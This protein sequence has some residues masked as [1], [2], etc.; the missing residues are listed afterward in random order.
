MRVTQPVVCNV[1]DYEEY[2]GKIENDNARVI[3]PLPPGRFEKTYFESGATVREGDLLGEFVPFSDPK[4]QQAEEKVRAARH[5]RNEL[6]NS[7]DRAK[8]RAAD[9]QE[10]AAEDERERVISKA[11][12]MK[13]VAPFDG[14]LGGGPGGE[15]PFVISIAPQ[16]AMLV[17]FDV[18]ESAVLAHCRL[19]NRKPNWELSLPVVCAL[20]D[21]KSFPYRGK[22][23]SVGDGI[24]PTTNT[25]RR[26]ALVPNKDGIFLPGMS[27]RVR[28]ITGEPHKILA[29]PGNVDFEYLPDAGHENDPVPV[30]IVN[31]QNVIETRMVRFWLGFD[32][33]P[34]KNMVNFKGD[35]AGLLGV[36]EGLSV[37]DWVVL[38][39]KANG[40]APGLGAGSV[41]TPKKV[42]TPLP[43][44]ATPASGV[45]PPA[46]A[47]GE[48]ATGQI[49]IIHLKNANAPNAAQALERIFVT[50]GATTGPIRITVDKRLNA[51]LVQANHA[52]FEKIQQVTNQ[53][54]A[55]LVPLPE[56]RDQIA[57]KSTAPRKVAAFRPVVQSTP[58]YL[59]T[60]GKIVTL[61][62]PKDGP[63]K[64]LQFEIDQPTC[65]K[66]MQAAHKRNA[67]R[68]AG[69]DPFG[70][71]SA[72]PKPA[73]INLASIFHINYGY[74]T[75]DEK[76]FPHRAEF[77][78]WAEHI[79]TV[80]GA[81][82]TASIDKSDAIAAP[83]MSVLVRLDTGATH[84]NLAVSQQAI[85]AEGG[86]QFVYVVNDDNVV[87]RRAVEASRSQG[88]F[89][90]VTGVKR[91]EIV[92]ADPSAVEPGMSVRPDFIAGALLL[93]T[94]PLEFVETPLK[95]VVD[96][97]KD[98]LHIEMLLDT[99]G[100][101]AARVDPDALISINLRDM[102]FAS[103]FKLMLRQVGLTYVVED[104]DILIT[105]PGKQPGATVSE[106]TATIRLEHANLFDTAVTLDHRFSRDGATTGP[107]RI[108]VDP[109]LHA[110]LIQAN[111]EDSEKIQKAAAEFDANQTVLPSTPGAAAP[112]PTVPPPVVRVTQP[113]VCNVCDYEEYTGRIEDGV[114][115]IRARFGQY[116]KTYFKEGMTVREGDLLGEVVPYND[117]K[118]SLTVFTS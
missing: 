63:A 21:D 102:S 38:R 98:C 89:R 117:P 95:D 94:P 66:M 23:V 79:P 56:H 13:I 49:A 11:P 101:T 114:V 93:P 24:D 69:P 10:K 31:N 90:I 15:Y 97:L 83:G 84:E 19:P 20:A 46:A 113:V 111:H 62:N 92:I 108:T 40:L 5:V 68:A 28:V 75:A 9:A 55:K 48:T 100:P 73:A 85:V 105:S 6:L 44:G 103:A 67:R 91:N 104:E 116:E 47:Q 16:D 115:Y 34:E 52:D 87:Q 22:I 81:T 71:G 37:N 54:D 4:I 50:E 42:A 86:K 45:P 77:K 27:V 41:V 61:A 118:V 70:N 18:P 32:I 107:F 106:P 78:S 57:S 25:Q 3:I 30:K 80:P 74:A 12:R 1:S 51:L 14:K 96:Y 8:A 109:R 58:D 99:Q 2:T 112:A 64:C 82:C 72:A 65:I 39:D 76:D 110:L 26:Q 60:T 33:Q 88:G 59:E 43:T 7:E 17:A 36:V 29:V 53:L 35:I